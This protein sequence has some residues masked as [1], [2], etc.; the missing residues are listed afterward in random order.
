MIWSDD[1]RAGCKAILAGIV[2]PER[3]IQHDIT[4]L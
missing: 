1:Q 3:F 2:P 4:G